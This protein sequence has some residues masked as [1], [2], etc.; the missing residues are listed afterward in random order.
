MSVTI[1]VY[2]TI[3]FFQTENNDLAKYLKIRKIPNFQTNEFPNTIL[4]NLPQIQH[5]VTYFL[6]I[7]SFILQFI[8][9]C[10]APKSYIGDDF[11]H[12][13]LIK[14][15]NSF[16]IDYYV[17]FWRYCVVEHY[18]DIDNEMYDPAGLEFTST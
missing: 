15:S 8:G 12:Q 9:F 1:R 14:I 4:Q 10:P 6:Y 7:S 2:K 5:Q 18:Q 11:F 3:N 16:G 17:G 13:K